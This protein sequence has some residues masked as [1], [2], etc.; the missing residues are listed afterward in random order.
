MERPGPDTPAAEIIAWLQPLGSARN[1]EGMARYGIDTSA[2]LSIPNAVLRP[3]ARDLKRNHE[4]AAELWRSGLR[5]AR[6]LALFTDEPAKVTADQAR[7]WAADFRSWEIVDHAADL[8]VDA[9][10]MQDMV[11]EF[12]ADEREHV[13]RCAFAMLAWAAVH[14]KE[15]PDADFIAW[16]PLVEK[17][18][19]D[20][21]NPV[22]KA[23]NWALRQIGKR[24][25]ACHG[26]ALDLARRLASS[27]D[28]S[29]RWI[30][31]DAVRELEGEK[32]IARIAA[33]RK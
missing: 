8:F 11:P 14:M 24:S 16:L 28:R 22:R 27:T 4:R 12:A 31:K 1:R 2:A 17:H 10:L 29:A 23:V 33:R 15:A 7:S 6:L 25:L 30:G 21:R 26:A 3:L 13:R 18:A 5:E 9:G 20:G 32:T 19:K